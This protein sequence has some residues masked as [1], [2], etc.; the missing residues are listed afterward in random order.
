MRHMSV[1]ITGAMKNAKMFVDNIT[2]DNRILQTEKEVKDY[3]QSQLD[4]GRRVLPLGNCDNFD[5]QTGCLGHEKRS[6]LE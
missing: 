4:L 6:K 3:F 2:V 1:D 5:Y